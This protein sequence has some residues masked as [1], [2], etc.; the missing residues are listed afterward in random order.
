MADISYRTL[1]STL[2]HLLPEQ[3]WDELR[4]RM[5]ERTFEPN[6]VIL[7]QGALEPDFHVIIQGTASVVAETQYGHTVP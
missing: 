6:D 5:E 3:V 1:T 2:F 7:E 4:L